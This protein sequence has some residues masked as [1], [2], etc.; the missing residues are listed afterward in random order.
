MR[1]GHCGAEMGQSVRF[2]TQCGS[3]LR[4]GSED[5]PPSSPSPVSVSHTPPG[6]PSIPTAPLEK[7]GSRAKQRN[8][9]VYALA[10]VA[11]A[12]IGLGGWW[13]VSSWHA[14]HTGRI[15]TFVHKI[16]PASAAVPAKASV[17]PR[18]P[19]QAAISVRSSP[20]SVEKESPSIASVPHGA[21]AHASAGLRPIRTAHQL[22]SP[23][24]AAPV[25]HRALAN[26]YANQAYKRRK[27][28]E[29]KK[30]LS[31]Q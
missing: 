25:A 7:P 31:G 11:V 12:V 8:W 19:T 1:C 18:L 5:S 30:L 28:R 4:P 22:R 27:E 17:L 3:L 14:E 26:P 29:L 20:Q 6:P 15:K 16:P 10:G 21:R 2:C 23:R 13:G 9:R 24:K